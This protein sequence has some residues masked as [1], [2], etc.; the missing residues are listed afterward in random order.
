MTKPA[1][2]AAVVLPH[3]ANMWINGKEQEVAR[4]FV[5]PLLN[6]FFKNYWFTQFCLVFGEDS[7]EVHELFYRMSEEKI[8]MYMG[9]FN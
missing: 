2:R 8:D 7:P 6:E 5:D 1:P 9:R 4:I 3:I